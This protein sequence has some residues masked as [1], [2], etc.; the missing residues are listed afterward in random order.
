M[1]LKLLLHGAVNRR[2]NGTSSPDHVN[3]RQWKVLS[4]SAAC[5]RIKPKTYC[6]PQLNKRWIAGNR[7]LYVDASFQKP[8]SPSSNCANGQFNHHSPQPPLKK[9]HLKNWTN[10]L[11]TKPTSTYPF[12]YLGMMS[13]SIWGACAQPCVFVYVHV[14]RKTA[15]VIT[16]W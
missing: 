6:F 5:L 10:P 12:G 14:R 9:L 11:S 7:M 1:L 4:R 15:K 8:R 16:H 13:L 2:G 3:C